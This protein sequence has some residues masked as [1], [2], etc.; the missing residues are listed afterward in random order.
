MAQYLLFPLYW[1]LARLI[2]AGLKVFGPQKRIRTAQI[3]NYRDETDIRKFGFWSIRSAPRV[4]SWVRYD[5]EGI[6]SRLFMIGVTTDQLKKAFETVSDSPR[7][8]LRIRELF[9]EAVD[10]AVRSGA[11]NVLLAAA[12]KR[13]YRPGELEKVYPGVTFT[14]GDNFT[15]LLLIERIRITLRSLGR[16]PKQVRVLIIGPYGFLGGVALHFCHSLGCQIVGL[17]NPKRPGPL[18]ALEKKFGLRPVFNFQDVGKVDLVI[19]CSE[20]RPVQLTSKIVDMLRKQGRTLFVID[21]CEPSNMTPQAVKDCGRAVVRYDAGNGYSPRLKYTLGWLS[22]RVLRLNRGETWGCFC[23]NFLLA[24]H[25]EL[26]GDWFSVNPEN[27]AKLYQFYGE[28]EGK[29]SL[30]P[31]TC[32]GKPI[33]EASLEFEEEPPSQ[34]SW[35]RLA[36]DGI[37]GFLV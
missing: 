5:W 32:H 4:L 19:A 33:G 24:K 7:E 28:G 26:V 37:R 34:K 13:L 15:G 23:E 16:D 36:F 35:L 30:P 9:R 17:G 27:I 18:L 22:Y 10:E 1:L 14:L 25:P 3:S 29:F 8:M 31:P 6:A 20:A 12:T 11:T 21:P 2:R